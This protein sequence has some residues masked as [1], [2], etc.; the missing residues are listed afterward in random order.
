[1]S[2]HWPP[3]SRGSPP[4]SA[5]PPPL[6]PGSPSPGSP[7][8]APGS[9]SPSP[10]L[11]SDSEPRSASALLE[12]PQAPAPP[13]AAHSNEIESTDRAERDIGVEDNRG[14][15]RV[16]RPRRSSLAAARYAVPLRAPGN[17]ART[18]KPDFGRSA[19]KN[20]A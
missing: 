3:P 5:G 15:R 10:E 13:I 7:S 1:W 12:S 11:S 16:A 6:S 20:R 14:P 8:P 19:I 4:R 2:V 17:R 18:S 9:P